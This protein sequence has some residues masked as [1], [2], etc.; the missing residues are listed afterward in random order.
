MSWN[1]EGF[2][3]NIFNIRHFLDLYSPDLV[4]LSEPQIHSCNLDFTASPLAGTYMYALNSADKF[5]PELPLVK[6]KAHGGTMVLW[7]AEHDPYIT[8]YLVSTTA[9]LPIIFHPPRSKLSI[10]FAV[11]LPTLGLENNF[12]NELSKLS[13][14]VDELLEAYPEAPVYL[15]GDFNV[16][17]RNKNR[18]DLLNHFCSQHHLQQLHMPKVTYHHFTGDGVS[19][20]F[21]DRIFFSSSLKH[22]EIIKYF[23]C[24]L[25]NPL[26]NSHH[27]IILSN[28]FVSREDPVNQSAENIVAPLMPN[29]RVRV[30]WSDPGIDQYQS[31]VA[32]QLQRIQDLWLSSPS[33][34]SV[35][36][37]LESTNNILSACA[38][39]SN[40]TIQLDK[41]SSTRPPAIPKPIRLS[42]NKLLKQNKALKKAIETGTSSDSKHIG[43]LKAAYNEAR[44]EHRKLERSFKAKDAVDRD[45]KFY[46]ILSNDPS[47][48]FNSIKR[49]KRAK[50]GKINNLKVRDKS[51]VGDSVKDGF[52]DSISTLKTRDTAALSA[53]EQYSEFSWDYLNILEVCRNG[54]PIPIITEAESFALLQRLK[55]HVNDVYG[56]T[57]DHYNYAGPAG[58]KHFHLLLTTLLNDVNLT[59]IEEV[60]VVYA[61][62]LFKGHGKDKSLDRS[63]RTI[64]TCPVVAK[65]LDLFIRDL[66]ISDWNLDQAETQ[67]QGEGSSHELAA[68]LLTEVIQHSLYSLNKPVYTL[69]LD[70]MSAFDVV[71]KELLVR[72]LFHCNTNGDTLLYINN[73]LENRQTCID[74]E[75]QIMGPIVDERGLEQGGVSSSDLYKIYGKEQLA[76]AQQSELGVKLGIL[77][78]SGIGQADDTALVTN[79]IKNLLFLLQLSIE[80]CNKYHVKLCAEKTKLQVY[81]TKAMEAEVKYAKMTNPITLNGMKVDFVDCAEHVGLARSTLGNSVPLFTRIS[82]HKKALGAVLHSGMARGHRG[83]PAASLRVVQLYGAPVLLSGIAALVLSKPDETIIDHHYKDIIMNIQKLLPG[84]PRAVIFFLAGTLP[85]TALLHLRQLSIFGMICRLSNNVIHQHAV[86]IMSSA[87]ISPK[88]WFLMIRNICLQYL[89]PHPLS[90]L[91]YPPSQDAFKNLVKKHVVDYWERLLRAEAEPLTSLCFFKPQFMSLSKPHPIWYTA[92]SSPSKIS[93]AVSQALMVSGRYRCEK[94]CSNWSQNKAGVCL[95]SKECVSQEE[96]IPHILRFCSG[97]DSTREKLK[98]FTHRYCMTAPPIIRDLATNLCST[99]SPFFCQFLLDCSVLPSVITATQREAEGE[100]I[101][102]HLFHLSRTWVFNLHRERL[103]LLGRWNMI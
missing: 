63:Y 86:N 101:L 67:F 48:I 7:K 43:E 38:A 10:H 19:D 13:L 28:W 1:C 35:S 34:T 97:L 60:N 41:P 96:D 40:R 54:P 47:G 33:L 88:S 57:A 2:S 4:F 14:T 12:V 78:I 25:E 31:M 49:A 29:T 64:S 56:I 70:A 42:K 91:Q 17:Q 36:L 94:L 69:Y 93:M 45:T 23:E 65:A 87:T 90:L 77:T 84:T 76:T 27:D 102:G 53:S 58:W 89:L 100:D 75:G 74:W 92:G 98:K 8:V 80:F 68:V 39:S 83:N 16:S 24:K 55:P 26:V 15:R 6:S 37:F 9:F 66:S 103:R 85:G 59:T 30:L 18:T 22:P 51:Y 81:F 72:N 44:I 95:I 5:D 82:A 61:C 52:F 21:L 20:S 99:S 11:Y 3:R 32:P 79:S 62:I 73:R 71:L 46:S 50:A